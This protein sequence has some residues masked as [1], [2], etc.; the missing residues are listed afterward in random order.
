MSGLQFNADTASDNALNDYEQGTWTPNW[1]GMD[2]HGS[3]TTSAN[4]ASYVKV[5]RMC[6]VGGYAVITGMT[7]SG[8]I[9]ITNLPFSAPN[10]NDYLRTGSFF[11]D[12]V[13]FSSDWSWLVTYK[14]HNDTN[15][16]IYAS[17]DN[18]GWESVGTT[19]G[20][21]IWSLTYMTT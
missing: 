18:A 19:T 10:G 14:T 7:G 3:T 5:G 20:S 15:M 8:P 1:V 6:S 13:N 4:V 12:T 9:G 11:C 21:F 2:N 17:R 16:R